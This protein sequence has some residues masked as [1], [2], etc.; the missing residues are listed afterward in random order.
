VVKGIVVL[1]VYVIGALVI[2]PPQVL[3]ILTV[4]AY[5]PYSM[6]YLRIIPSS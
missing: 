3:P 1:N 2:T 6:F 5:E 4:R